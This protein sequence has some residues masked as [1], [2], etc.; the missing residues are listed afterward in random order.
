MDARCALSRARY[1]SCISNIK[2]PNK[3]NASGS[4]RVKLPLVGD[5]VAGRA[6]DTIRASET[7]IG[8][9]LAGVRGG[10]AI[11]PNRALSRDEALVGWSQVVGRGTGSAVVKGV[12]E[13][14]V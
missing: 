11:I 12:A 2:V 10:I 8:T 1:T 5:R 3:R 13:G 9:A 14:A 4:S 7:I 6:V